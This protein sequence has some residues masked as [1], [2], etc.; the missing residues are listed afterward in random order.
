MQSSTLTVLQANASKGKEFECFSFFKL[1]N[2]LPKCMAVHEQQKVLLAAMCMAAHNCQR[3]GL[4]SPH[5]HSFFKENHAYLCFSALR[6]HVLESDSLC[7]HMSL[8][9]AIFE[10]QKGIAW[11]TCLLQH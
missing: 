5:F 8:N 6:T 7:K 9:Q 2:M 1:P 4:F 11:L 3:M 10:R